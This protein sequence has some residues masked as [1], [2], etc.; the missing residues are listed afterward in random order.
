MALRRGNSKVVAVRMRIDFVRTLKKRANG[1]PISAYIRQVLQ[2]SGENDIILKL[3]Q[4]QRSWAEGR[5]REKGF[6]SIAEYLTEA[7][8]EGLRKSV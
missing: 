8:E 6:G 1:I 4:A 2:S 5:A 3:T 7:I